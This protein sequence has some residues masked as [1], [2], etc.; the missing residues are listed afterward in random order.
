[1]SE[2]FSQGQVTE[3]RWQIR[4]NFHIGGAVLL[5]RVVLGSLQKPG[6]GG[7]AGDS[8]CRWHQ[9]AHGSKGDLMMLSKQVFK[10]QRRLCKG[11]QILVLHTKQGSQMRPRANS[12]VEMLPNARKREETSN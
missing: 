10:W 9:M 12:S 3:Q 8:C 4:C 11:K 7:Q 2:R 5:C 1:M 6:Q